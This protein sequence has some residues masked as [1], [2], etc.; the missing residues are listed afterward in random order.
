MQSP[1]E[2]VGPKVSNITNGVGECNIIHLPDYWKE[3][4]VDETDMTVQLTPIGNNCQ[5][6]VKRVTKETVEI[7]CECGKPNCYYIIH[8][9]RYNEGKFEILEPKIRKKL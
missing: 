2:I 4:P 7:E 5:H 6:W 3:L 9:Q 1:T 8:A